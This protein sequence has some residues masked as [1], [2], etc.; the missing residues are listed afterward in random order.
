MTDFNGM[1][2]I[3]VATAYLTGWE[4]RW[5]PTEHPCWSSTGQE[6]LQGTGE[7]YD[8]EWSHTERAV[9]K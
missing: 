4:D 5:L 6:S 1:R 2:P 8:K 3:I 9:S 7:V